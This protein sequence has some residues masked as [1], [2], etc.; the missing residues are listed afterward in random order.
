[1]RAYISRRDADTYSRNG[2]VRVQVDIEMSLSIDFPPDSHLPAEL[3]NRM[4]A[5]AEAYVDEINASAKAA[6]KK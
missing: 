5:T 2:E 3:A 4:I 6:E 1:M